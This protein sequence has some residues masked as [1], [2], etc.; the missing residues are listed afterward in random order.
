MRPPAAPEAP[1]RSGGDRQRLAGLGVGALH[2]PHVCEA[3]QE[4]PGDAAVGDGDGA[5]DVAP[6]QGHE[7]APG[8]VRVET[9]VDLRGGVGHPVGAPGTRH[10]DRH[11]RRVLVQGGHRATARC[12]NLIPEA[13][14][15][16]HSN[17]DTQPCARPLGGTRRGG[18]G[19][20][21]GRLRGVWGRGP[22]GGKGA[23]THIEAST[24]VLGYLTGTNTRCVT[25]ALGRV[26]LRGGGA[27]APPPTPSGDPELL[28][29]PNK[30]FG[31]N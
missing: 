19:G 25:T 18:W 10:G 29:A 16:A 24:S 23:A 30:F 11:R 12:E 13:T 3:D 26:S 20:G 22:M 14:V 31:L 17:R 9:D 5:R 6:V 7:G 15:A 2:A 21:A 27:V 8:P 4:P 1:R 28:E